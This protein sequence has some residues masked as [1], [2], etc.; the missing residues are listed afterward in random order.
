MTEVVLS[1][2]TLLPSL[3]LMASCGRLITRPISAKKYLMI[4]TLFDFAS[5]CFLCSELGL[6]RGG[7]GIEAA[8]F[9][10]HQDFVKLRGQHVPLKLLLLC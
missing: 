9:G 4:F 2:W 8:V 10:L 7:V 5:C 3:Y 1:S 6:D